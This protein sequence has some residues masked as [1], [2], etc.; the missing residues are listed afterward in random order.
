MVAV[1]DP[2]ERVLRDAVLAADLAAMEIA[3]LAGVAEHPAL[4]PRIRAAAKRV[5]DVVACIADLAGPE[6]V[7]EVR[8]LKV[9]AGEEALSPDSGEGD[10]PAHPEETPPFADGTYPFSVVQDINLQEDHGAPGRW[11]RLRQ[12]LLDLRHAALPPAVSDAEQLRRDIALAL[13]LA[14]VRLFS[15]A[16]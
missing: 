11:V 10:A 15:R 4:G 6:L 8:A 13:T 16:E 12:R 7:S 9:L 1:F 14:A 2:V 3:D 5:D